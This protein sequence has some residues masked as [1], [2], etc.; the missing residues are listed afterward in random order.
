MRT[1]DRPRSALKPHPAVPPKQNRKLR[2]SACPRRPI[3]MMRRARR[4]ARGSNRKAR[5]TD[6]HQL[7]HTLP[8]RLL[9]HAGQQKRSGTFAPCSSKLSQPIA[10]TCNLGQAGAAPV[11]RPDPATRTIFLRSRTNEPWIST[12]GTGKN[13]GPGRNQHDAP[14]E[15]PDAIEEPSTLRPGPI[16][17]FRDIFLI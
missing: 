2:R 14:Q 5:A 15:S 3:R 12:S 17:D 7:R 11:A 9:S 4:A 16:V 10:D 8:I 6:D 13:P 1:S